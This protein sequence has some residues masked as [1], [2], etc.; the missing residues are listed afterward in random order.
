MFENISRVIAEHCGR[1]YAF[2]LSVLVVVIWGITGPIFHYSDT[3][4][5]IINTGTT[6]VTFWLV[7]IIQSTQN[8]DQIALQL[9]LDELIRATKGARDE[10]AGIEDKTEKE[11]RDLKGEH[12]G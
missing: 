7:F 9:K 2:I 1:A 3:W 4:Q 8:R 10:I 12:D 6:V 5:L 11:L